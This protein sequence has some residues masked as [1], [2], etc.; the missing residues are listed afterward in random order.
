MQVSAHALSGVMTGAR[1]AITLIVFGFLAAMIAGRFDV[2]LS[3]G[4]IQ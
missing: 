4:K 3:T 1:M 2:T